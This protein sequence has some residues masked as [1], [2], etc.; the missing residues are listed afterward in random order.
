MRARVCMCVFSQVMVHSAETMWLVWVWSI[1]CSLSSV[2]PSPSPSCAMSPGSWSTCAATRTLHHPWRRSWRCVC[3]GGQCVTSGDPRALW[4]PI[5]R[6]WIVPRLQKGIFCNDM[7]AKLPF[8]LKMVLRW[9]LM[10]QYYLIHSNIKTQ[11]LQNFILSTLQLSQMIYVCS[12]KYR[13]REIRWGKTISLYWVF[14]LT[15]DL[16]TRLISSVNLRFGEQC[17]CQ[18]IRGLHFKQFQS[19]HSGVPSEKLDHLQNTVELD[20]FKQTPAVMPF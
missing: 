18:N 8:C 1:P 3:T 7:L 15:Q 6:G 17:S 5:R 13:D 4:S 14:F 12:I 10:T 9:F 16:F 19:F 11:N 2:L 20:L